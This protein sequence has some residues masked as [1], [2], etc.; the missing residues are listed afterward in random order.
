MSCLS[1]YIYFFVFFPELLWIFLLKPPEIFY[2]W[3]IVPIN[4]QLRPY[5]Q[6]F[7]HLR[8]ISQQF[9]LLK[10][11]FKI[12]SKLYVMKED[13][14]PLFLQTCSLYYILSHILIKLSYCIPRFYLFP[15]S[16]ILVCSSTFFNYR[17]V[18][19]FMPPSGAMGVEIP[20]VGL[21]STVAARISCC[22]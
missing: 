22:K 10:V 21:E 12:V 6:W 15:R 3:N 13:M 8:K 18:C 19:T 4:Y 14:E 5:F 7:A 11:Y 9:L 1:T 20:E 16:I 2:L 17:N